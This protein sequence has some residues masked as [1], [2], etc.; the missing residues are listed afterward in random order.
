[1]TDS[2]TVETSRYLGKIWTRSRTHVFL[3]QCHRRISLDS[4]GVFSFSEEVLVERILLFP[5][6][7]IYSGKFISNI[8]PLDPLPILLFLS[9]VGAL[10]FF[11]GTEIPLMSV[12]QHKLDGWIKQKKW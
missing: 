2:E 1:M 4:V 5:D 7:S 12:S 10:A 8:L 9:L 11:A 3:T 6:F